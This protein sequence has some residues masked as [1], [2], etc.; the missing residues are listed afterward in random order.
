MSKAKKIVEIEPNG[1]IDVEKFEFTGYKCPHCSGRGKYVNE[2]G[3]DKYEES[4][5]D[6]CKGAGK[7]QCSVIVIWLPQFEEMESKEIQTTK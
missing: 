3:R 6:F 5:C 2:V 7:V 1:R 4:D